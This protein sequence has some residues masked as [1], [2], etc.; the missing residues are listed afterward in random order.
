[1]ATNVDSATGNEVVTFSDFAKKPVEETK[2]EVKAEAET[3]AQDVAGDDDAEAEGQDSD[4]DSQDESQEGTDDKPK[5]KSGWQ[6]KIDKLTKRN[7]E[8][9]R[10]YE[11]LQSQALQKR[12]SEQA[13]DVV[14]AKPHAEGRPASDN[15]QTHEEYM[16]ALS[17]WKVE[18]KL[19]ERDTREQSAKA[20]AA[21]EA[22]ENEVREQA[23]EF[24]K[25]H[26]DFE[27]VIKDVDDIEMSLTVRESLLKSK[28]APELMYEL[29]KD[30]E[31]FER[32]CSLP[33]LDAAEAIGEIKARIKSAG[34]KQDA[35]KTTK[36]PR[37]LS[38]VSTKAGS[39]VKSIH[40]P[41]LSFAEYEKLRNEQL[42][43]K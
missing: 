40:D 13:D 29:A 5:R 9:A 23:Q 43:R 16:E 3:K 26:P 32:I 8:L 12:Q 41:G 28:N 42:K 34:T 31:E 33:A 30:P 18:Q 15:F 11:A 1:M 10:A 17:D 7:A 2:P 19:K 38:P 27:A 4:S 35:I 25:T 14:Q 37:P 39:V 21:A 20:K 36:A 24:A 22:R 6:R